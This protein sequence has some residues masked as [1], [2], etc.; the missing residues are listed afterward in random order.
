MGDNFLNYFSYNWIMKPV[1][2]PAVLPK[3]LEDLTFFLQKIK[4][5]S[6]YA[7]IDIADGNFVD[8][9]TINLKEIIKKKIS[10]EELFIELHLMVKNPE[11]YFSDCENLKA[12]RV[13]FH[14]EAFPKIND[15][16][17]VITKSEKFNFELGLAINPETPV[18]VI[19]NITDKINFFLFMTVKPGWQGQKFNQMVLEKIK[20]FKKIFPEKRVEV[21]GGVNDENIKQLVKAKVDFI[22][23][24]SYLIKS[25]NWQ[26]RFFHLQKLIN[27]F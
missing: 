2:I 10:F 13:I 18:E 26:E 12:K 3:N 23:V 8:N 4:T 16:I 17:N 9:K 27:K 11:N 5:F 25:K 24:G 19:K 7:Q 22:V 14:Y 1:V 15:L 6:N 21:D 20:K